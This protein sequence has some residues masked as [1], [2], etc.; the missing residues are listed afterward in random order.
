MEGLAEWK[1]TLRGEKGRKTAHRVEE[2]SNKKLDL[3]EI[4]KVIDN[5]KMWNKFDRTIKKFRSGNEVPEKDLKLAMASVMLTVKIQEHA[6]PW[7]CG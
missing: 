7:G 4:S 3:V 5:D 2:T 1:R 6:A